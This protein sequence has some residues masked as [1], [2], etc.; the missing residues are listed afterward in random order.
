[1]SY[2]LV[3]IIIPCYNAEAYIGDA[4]ES[5]LSQSYPAVEIILIDDGSTDQSLDV[6]RSFRGRIRWETGS[7]QGACAARN[8]GLSRSTGQIIQF[9]DSDDFLLPDKI[10]NQVPLLLRSPN[11][12]V[13]GWYKQVYEGNICS[14]V[15]KPD[16]SLLEDSVLL[17]LSHIIQT[18]PPL[19]WAHN[20][21]MVGGFNVNLPCN[22]DYDFNL[23]LACAGIHFI[24][25]NR[26]ASCKRRRPYSVSSNDCRR[27]KN[28]PPIFYA[29]YQN[30]AEQDAL[31]DAR[32]ATLAHQLALLV[33]SLVGCGELEMAREVNQV[34]FEVHPS[35]GIQSAFD[36]KSRLVRKLFGPIWAERII[37]SYQQLSGRQKK[38]P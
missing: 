14:E 32:R 26:Q 19:H 30:L 10:A 12:S 21:R 17:A 13:F 16:N 27:H 24:Y 9:L 7:R 4:I 8:K 25:D 11:Q 20:V 34:A 15:V 3:S 38:M 5:A 36:C 33:R 6:I 29:A 22:Q 35:G 31:S 1:M 37:Y 23:R 2:P 18:E 28:M